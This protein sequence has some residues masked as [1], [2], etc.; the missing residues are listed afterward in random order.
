MAQSKLVKRY[1]KRKRAKRNPSSVS[2]SLRR[3]PI[4]SDLVALAEQV[5]PGVAGFAA[6]RLATRAAQAAVA[7]RWP[8]YAN[9]AGAAASIGTVLLAYVGAHRVKA[10]EAYAPSIVVGSAIAAAQS[11]IQIYLPKLGWI[12][13]DASPDITALAPGDNRVIT[14]DVNGNQAVMGPGDF[15]VADDD[16]H[17][18]DYNDARDPG[19]TYTKAKQQNAAKQQA[20]AQ[21]PA[22]S[23]QAQ[24]AVEPSDDDS[25]FDVL[26]EDEMQ[27]QGWGAGL[28]QN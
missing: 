28:A 1:G 5:V 23:S 15:D 26:E 2:S 25:I 21:Q 16:S 7:K 11:I 10:L 22:P 4:V 19:P 6:G 17:W 13:S 20:Q 18:Y 14:T 12:V 8:K 3:N 9:H 27:H 24:Q